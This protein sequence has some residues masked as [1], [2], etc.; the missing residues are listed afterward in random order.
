M[1][2]CMVLEFFLPYY[3]GGGE[4]RCYEICKRVV[5]RGHEVDV[6]TM[7]IAGDTEFED[8]DGIHVHHIGPKVKK[9]P[10]RTKSNF[11][12]YFFSV[13]RW[14]LTHK[15]DII[16]AQAYS[17]LLSAYV[18]AKLSKTPIIGTIYDT[19]TNNNDQWL[20]SPS[21]ASRMEKILL[22]IH[23]NRA[24]TISHATMNS[25]IN[26]FGVNSKTLELVYCGVDIPKY[27][28]VTTDKLIK[29]QII[30]VGRLAPHKH[31]DHFIKVIKEIKPDYPDLKF[32]IVG[33]GPEKENL[34]KLIDNLELNDCITFKQD[35]TDEE[36]ITQIKQSEILVLPSTREGFGMVLAEANCCNKPVLTYASG[37]TVDVVEDGYNGYLVQAGNIQDFKEKTIKLLED[38]KLRKTIGSNGRKKVE[39]YFDWENITDEYIK[40]LENTI[41]KT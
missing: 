38:E 20:Q 24:I 27:D 25:L 18:G 16:D 22:N 30:F 23:F 15:Y 12:R 37:G 14:L 40:I 41:N 13:C 36:L 17:P 2:I 9:I 26:D 19:S 33:K 7:K 10:Y 31:V 39:E 5:E 34:V 29:D 35:L 6:L 8:M 28:K 3:N 32:L 4:H 11:I 1:K 21:I